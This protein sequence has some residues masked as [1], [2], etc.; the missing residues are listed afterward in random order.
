M[1][2]EFFD[3][4]QKATE[5]GGRQ[6]G[7]DGKTLVGRYRDGSMPE[8]DKRAYGV[9]QVQVGTGRNVA[10]AHGIPWDE[11]KFMNDAAYNER[12][13]ELHMKDLT[14]KYGDRQLALAAYHSGEPIVDKAIAKYGRSGFAQGLGPEGRAYIKM[15]QNGQTATP[16]ILGQLDNTLNTPRVPA[17]TKSSQNVRADNVKYTMGSDQELER[18]ADVVEEDLNSS[19]AQIGVLNE[20]SQI[21]QEAARGAMVQQVAETRAVSNAITEGTTELR[22]KVVPIFKARARVADQLDKINT[23]NPL[24]R[25]IRGIFDLNYDRDYLEGQLEHY[26]TTLNMRAQDY[27]YL[28]KLHGVA[29][30]EIQRRYQMDTAMPNLMAEQAKEDLGLIGMQIQNSA[31]LLGNLSDRI[32]TESKMIAAKAQARE[33]LLL[34]LDTPTI[35]DLMTQAQEAGGVVVHNGVEFSYKELHD[36]VQSANQQELQMESHRM[37]VASGRMDL[38]EKYA[39]NIAQGLTRGQLEAAIANGGVYNGVQIPQDVLTN[40]YQSA[41]SRDQ[42]RAADIANRMPARVALNTGADYLKQSMG[43][44]SRSKELFGNKA[45]EGSGVFLNQGAQLVEQLV[46]ATRNKEPPEVIA[47]LT[48]QI[49]VNSKNLDTFVQ[50]RI[51]RSVGGDKRAAG[52]M[53]AFVYG[54]ELSQGTAAEAMTYFAIKG[55]LPAGISLTPEARQVFAKAQTLVEQ[56][57]NQTVNGKPISE[58]QLQSMVTNQLTKDAPRIMGQA[59]HD[60]LFNELPAVARQSQH[61][62]S[63]FDDNRWAE[64]QAES[65]LTAGEAVAHTVGTTPDN[66]VRMLKTGKP[67]TQDENGK[68]LLAAT[69][70][71]AANFNAVEMQTMVRLVDAEPIIQNGTRNSTVMA[72]YLGSG[73]FANAV[74]TYGQALGAQSIGEYLTNPMTAGATERNFVETRKNLLQAQAT[75]HQ[76]DRQMAQN[77]ATNMLL[78][79]VSRTRMILEAIPGIGKPGAKALQPFVK[80]FY[81]KYARGDGPKLETPNSRF[82]REDAAMLAALQSTKF[83]DPTMESFRKQAVKNWEEHATRQQGFIERM[84]DGL[85]GEDVNILDAEVIPGAR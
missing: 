7:P 75:V 63:K 57:R 50:E 55:N 8:P 51:L 85:F 74:G 27:D 4:L 58:A 23:M 26:N 46:V 28:N 35:T 5:S 70:A 37:A 29:L 59:R 78:K 52:Y 72:D 38:A 20:V 68:K 56:N 64:I 2:G 13:A 84:V 43:L 47:A 12:L 39:V 24:E 32:G 18:R 10:K 25:G 49:A 31:N 41:I 61:P 54:T 42:T 16:R 36:R 76:T 80:D 40:L 53:Q 60:K 33:D 11:K 82:V 62:F 9:G 65:Q 34:R 66:V 19:R 14:A 3:D 81:S 17:E 77:P 83:E 67:L 73:K 15:G 22:E 71:E 45:M 21:A 48:Q 6:F 44:Y 1:F 30:Q 69:Q 79:P